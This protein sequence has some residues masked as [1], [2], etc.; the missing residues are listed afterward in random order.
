MLY[1]CAQEK[2]RSKKCFLLSLECSRTNSV[3][4][5]EKRQT[6]MKTHS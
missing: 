1:G 2:A 4:L 3:Y 6:K 5:C